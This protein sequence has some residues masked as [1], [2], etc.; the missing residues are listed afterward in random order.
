MTFLVSVKKASN[1]DMKYPERLMVLCPLYVLKICICK[2][3]F[4][5]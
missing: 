3:Y 2:I 5:A 1:N 4:V